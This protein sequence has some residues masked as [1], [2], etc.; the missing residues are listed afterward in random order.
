[1]D[2][3][4]SIKKQIR[5][6]QDILNSLSIVGEADVKIIRIAD[7]SDQRSIHKD[8]RVGIAEH[9]RKLGNKVQRERDNFGDIHISANDV[10][11]AVNYVTSDSEIAAFFVAHKVLR[12]GIIIGVHPDHKNKQ[13]ST[14]TFGAPV[15]LNDKRGNMAVVVA[16]TSKNR[17]KAHRILT[18][19]GKVFVLDSDEN[20]AHKGTGEI[21][22]QSSPTACVLDTDS[23]AQY[24]TTVNDEKISDENESR[25]N[26]PQICYAKDVKENYTIVIGS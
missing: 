11:R 10:N 25:V 7:G 3:T 18:P 20:Q 24:K 1:M 17:Y 22:A 26:E 8:I 15:K 5:E 13:F 19:D 23:V 6:H 12:H 4:D 9:F 14:V 2:S 21:V 16:V